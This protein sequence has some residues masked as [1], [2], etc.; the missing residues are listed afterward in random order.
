MLSSAQ[1][2]FINRMYVCVCV[3]EHTYTSRHKTKTNRIY[4]GNVLAPTLWKYGSR[5][6]IHSLF[7]LS[8]SYTRTAFFCLSVLDSLCMCYIIRIHFIYPLTVMEN[9]CPRVRISRVIFSSFLFH[10]VRS[11]QY[12]V[13][14]QCRWWTVKRTVFCFKHFKHR[15]HNECERHL[16]SEREK[17]SRCFCTRALSTYPCIV[18]TLN[19][20]YASIAVHNV[21]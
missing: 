13:H 17:E 2:L 16:E 19:V 14:R 1:V 4:T 20:V 21:R 10:I 11:E 5:R 6:T 9:S 18:Y 15:T 3:C 7:C 12:C 8:L